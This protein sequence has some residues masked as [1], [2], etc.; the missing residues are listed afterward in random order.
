M[1]FLNI[2][3]LLFISTDL[4]RAFEPFILPIN[5]QNNNNKMSQIDFSFQINDVAHATL[6]SAAY[7]E[8]HQAVTS[9]KDTTSLLS[10]IAWLHKLMTA[11]ARPVTQE[12][13]ISCETTIQDETAT[14]TATATQKKPTKLQKCCACG[15]TDKSTYCGSKP[16]KCSNCYGQICELT[17]GRC[18][19]IV[20]TAKAIRPC[21][22]RCRG[23]R[24][25]QQAKVSDFF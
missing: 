14:E 17:C 25:H 5:I 1:F 13:L 8:L 7:Q 21:D 12:S 2:L 11:Q 24:S 22:V 3:N 20:K 10:R 6:L 23:C 16:W 9:G 19:T 15:K 4:S 18:G